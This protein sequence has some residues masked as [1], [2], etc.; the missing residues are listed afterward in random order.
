MTSASG[1]PSYTQVYV[2][3]KAIP[4]PLPRSDNTTSSTLPTSYREPV[5]GS[6]DEKNNVDYNTSQAHQS[7]G[8]EDMTLQN[9][10]GNQSKYATRTPEAKRKMK[11]IMRTGYE[12][13]TGKS[14]DDEDFPL[15]PPTLPM[16]K[17]PVPPPT[18]PLKQSHVF[19]QDSSLLSP[20]KISSGAQRRQESYENVMPKQLVPVRTQNPFNMD[21]ATNNS[22]TGEKDDRAPTPPPPTYYDAPLKPR[23]KSIKPSYENFKPPDPVGTTGMRSYENFKPPGSVEEDNSVQVVERKVFKST[24]DRPV[25]RKFLSLKF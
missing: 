17:S 25:P 5:P 16:K 7:S 8:Y 1:I 14:S 24:T 9:S 21:Y 2:S 11:T 12:D 19:N 18:L 10:S 20:K 22:H 6:S 13:M 3:D 23:E 4:H 15:P